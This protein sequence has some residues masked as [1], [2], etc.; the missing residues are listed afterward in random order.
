MPSSTPCN[1][2]FFPSLFLF[3]FLKKFFT[4]LSFKCLLDFICISLTEF[5]TQYNEEV[6]IRISG[7]QLSG[8]SPT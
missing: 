4:E 6:K 7:A 2:S 3:F 1:T 8:L 5:Y